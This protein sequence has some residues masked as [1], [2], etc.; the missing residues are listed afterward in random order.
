MSL[1]IKLLPVIEEPAAE[2]HEKQSAGEVQPQNKIVIVFF[3][4]RETYTS[5]QPL[6]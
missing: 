3:L 5:L 1:T 4:L 6:R 2:H